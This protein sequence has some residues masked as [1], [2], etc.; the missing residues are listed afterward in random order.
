[1]S[2]QAKGR[3]FH[4]M[5]CFKSARSEPAGGNAHRRCRSTIF[6]CPP[7]GGLKHD[8]GTLPLGA[9]IYKAYQAYQATCFSEVGVQP[10]PSQL[11]YIHI[12]TRE[13]WGNS[14]ST[15]A[16]PVASANHLGFFNHQETLIRKPLY[17]ML[18]VLTPL[19]TSESSDS[20][21]QM[22]SQTLIIN[23]LRA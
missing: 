4:V 11:I 12:Y 7:E 21:H 6:V 14:H 18:S 2:K 22:L 17:F 1:M 8:F 15:T 5:T 20:D 3:Y 23:A 9:L 10:S 16:R 19:F 13:V